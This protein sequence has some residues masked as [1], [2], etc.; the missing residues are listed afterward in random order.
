MPWSERP[1]GSYCGDGVE[2]VVV[3]IVVE[4]EIVADF[5]FGSYTDIDAVH[6]LQRIE[7]EPERGFAE[8]DEFTTDIL[9]VPHINKA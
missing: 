8:H 5:D 1:L 6:P 3:A 7:V 2:L 4:D 9:V